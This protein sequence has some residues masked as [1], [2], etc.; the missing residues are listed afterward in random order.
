[1]LA[2]SN[3]G[4]IFTSDQMS[5]VVIALLNVI[6]C[7]GVG[8]LMMPFVTWGMSGLDNKNTANGT[9]LITSLRTVS[10]AFGAAIF[11]GMVNVV[12]MKSTQT[13]GM[14]VAFL[15]LGIIGLIEVALAIY[16]AR[17]EV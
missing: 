5:L 4:M 2:F 13:A 11:V 16:V 7:L 15:A 1:M 10:G 14:Q 12:A 3:L 17:K 8:C 9:A 6:R